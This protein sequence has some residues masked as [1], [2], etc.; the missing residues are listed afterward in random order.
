VLVTAVTAPGF[1]WDGVSP[2]TRYCVHA[3]PKKPAKKTKHSTA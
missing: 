1:S 3:P 2:Q